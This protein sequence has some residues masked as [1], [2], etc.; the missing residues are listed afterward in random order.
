MFRTISDGIPKDRAYPDRMRR[1]DILTRILDG[2]F[3]D[4]LPVAFHDEKNDAGEYVPLRKRRPSVQ[5]N[6]TKIIVDESVSMLF[7][8]G[9]FPAVECADEDTRTALE[10]VLKEA[11]INEAMLHG[12]TI[13]S[14][15]SVA[16]LF[17]V[18]KNR[19][20][21][22]A[23]GTRYLTPTWNPEAPDQLLKVRE[24]YKS[25]GKDLIA[26]GYVVEK[27]D[28]NYWFARDWDSTSETIFDPW[29][30]GEEDPKRILP[31]KSTNHKLGFVPVVWVKNLPGGDTID[32]ACTF[33][34]IIPDQI[35]IDYQLSQLG[36]GLK[37]SQ[38]PTLLLK[39]P[40]VEG[41]Q[42][43]GGGNALIVSEG[44]DGKLLEISGGAAEAVLSFVR[45]LREY[46]LEVGHGNRSNADKLSAAQSGKAMELMN[47]SLL[48]LA[49]NLRISYGNHGL[50]RL[51]EMIRAS[52]KQYKLTVKGIELPAMDQK[53]EIT[54]RWPPWYAPTSTE[55]QADANT[56]GTAKDK[57]LVSQETAVKVLSGAYDIEDPAAELALIR[58]EQAEQL[59]QLPAPQTKIAEAI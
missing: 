53:E 29:P 1:I 3:Y 43:K 35:E 58:K 31:D 54:L 8:E 41:E 27:P 38:D 59:A 24:Q 2:T 15:G 23:V 17:R 18:L 26:A 25:K 19:I 30:V 49:D 50:V 10:N 7:S 21:V 57:G 12:A 45:D 48:M 5:Y 39:E 9:H 52:Q 33:G 37:Y 40:V 46:A 44:G 47:H 22:N 11:R 36:R 4:H 34:Q 51:L 55:K 56:L 14:V 42:I 16:F 20:F 6:M 32:G 28:A 13:G